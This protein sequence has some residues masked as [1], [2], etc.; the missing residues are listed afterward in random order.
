ML[1]WLLNLITAKREALRDI[2]PLL[3]ALLHSDA[4]TEA[5]QSTK[6]PLDDLV[7]RILRALIPAE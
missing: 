6:S 4:L 1:Q 5:V 3:K 7:L 2:S